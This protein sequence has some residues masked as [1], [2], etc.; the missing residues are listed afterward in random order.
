MFLNPKNLTF[1]KS[2]VKCACSNCHDLDYCLTEF[3]CYR[4]SADFSARLMEKSF[5]GCFKSSI[6]TLQVR[7][8]S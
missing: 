8:F 1:Q 5:F 3:S 4:A 7:D 6:Q 2:L